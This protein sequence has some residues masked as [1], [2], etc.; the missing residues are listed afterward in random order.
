MLAPP[1]KLNR[2]LLGKTERGATAG[3]RERR[4]LEPKGPLEGGREK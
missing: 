1:G 4:P 2:A 3:F